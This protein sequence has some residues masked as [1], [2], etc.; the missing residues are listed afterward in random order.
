MDIFSA[1]LLSQLTEKGF[2]VSLFICS[3]N[4]SPSLSS[5]VWSCW[6]SF[7]ITL[8]VTLSLCQDFTWLWICREHRYKPPRSPFK[9]RFVAPALISFRVCV[10]EDSLNQICCREP[11]FPRSYFSWAGP[12]S[13]TYQ[14]SGIK[15]QTSWSNESRVG[16]QNTAWDKYCMGHTYAKKLPVVYLKFK[17]TGYPVF[18]FTK[19]GNLKWGTALKG[20]LWGHL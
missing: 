16:R 20:C 5:K 14:N 4:T 15:T 18:L 19:S 13:M 7:V 11:S 3:T 12:Q 2:V 9:E 1:S 6:S 8:S 17:L 10:R